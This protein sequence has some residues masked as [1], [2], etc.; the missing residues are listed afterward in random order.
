MFVLNNLF[1]PQSEPDQ[2]KIGLNEDGQIIG[3]NEDLGQFIETD[4]KGNYSP[5][6]SQRSSDIESDKSINVN[7]YQGT[8]PSHGIGELSPSDDEIYSVPKGTKEQSWGKTYKN[9][10]GNYPKKKTELSPGISL[11]IIV[12]FIFVVL[13][14]FAIIEDFSSSCTNKESC[15]L[16]N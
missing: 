3:L 8:P 7:D 14:T 13:L 5:N 1:N 11:I 2:P 6:S 4:K 10:S 16:I 12:I 15:Q 9:I